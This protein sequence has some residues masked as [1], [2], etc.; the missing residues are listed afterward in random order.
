M[1]RAM[2][3]AA[4]AGAKPP[5]TV[6]PGFTC[7]WYTAVHRVMKPGMPAV[8]TAL[9]GAGAS[10]STLAQSG[11]DDRLAV[12][13]SGAT[14]TGTNGGGAAT[15]GWL[16]NFSANTVLGISGDYQ[17]LGDARWKFGSLNLAHGF[18][19]ASRR[20]NLY[21]EGHEGSG[22]DRVHSY[23]YSIYAAGVFQNLTRQLAI[24][25][26]DKQIDVDT[27]EGNLPKIGVQYLWTPALLTTLTYSHSVSGN[28]GTRVGSLRVDR[29]G[30]GVNLLAGVAGGQTSPIVINLPA[31]GETDTVPQDL[32]QVFVGATWPFPRADVGFL[33]DYQKLESSERFTLSFTCM[34]R[35]RGTGR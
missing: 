33:A 13:L 11:V 17:R 9:I 12:T 8:V 19:E 7:A 27:V 32:R 34:V 21:V 6:S 10:A 35:L 15:L 20:T 14:L 4:K 31:T 22:E 28:L 18:G 30:K 16:H 26:E 1:K 29:Y 24:Q 25:L 5:G 23:D 2:K 3:P